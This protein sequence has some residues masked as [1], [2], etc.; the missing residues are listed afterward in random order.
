MPTKQEAAR[1]R[2][3]RML[4][5][6][7]LLAAIVIVIRLAFVAR[8]FDT[9]AT[10]AAFESARSDHTQLRAFLHRMPKGGD[11]HTHLAGAVYAE[12][13]IAW[14]A[15]QGLCADLANALA[16]KPHCDPPADVSV[17]EALRDQRL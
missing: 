2:V 3:L 12:R 5:A 15:E 17:A 16:A 14:A 7:G 11:L 1:A 4:W 13:F 6:A 8:D 10:A 9:I